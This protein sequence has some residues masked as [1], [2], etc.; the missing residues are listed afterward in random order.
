MVARDWNHP[1]VMIWTIVNENWG[2]DLVK[3]AADRQWLFE[4]VTWARSIAPTR[5]IV[6]NS[7]CIP[8]FH[9]Q[10]DID[11]YHFYAAMPEGVKAWQSYVS[12]FAQR[13]DWSFSPYGD[14]HRTGREPLIISEFGNWGLPDLGQLAAAY[15]GDPWW[16]RT[17]KDWEPDV[18]WPQ[19]AEERFNQAG[20]NHVFSNWA[21]LA[22]AAQWAQYRAL[23]HEIEV[24]R[25]EP[26]LSGYVITEWTDLHWECNGLVD[27]AR[28]PR[29]FANRMPEFNAD[30]VIIPR[31]PRL[32]YWSGEPVRLDIQ[33]AH[34]GSLPL[35]Q[36]R[37]Y[38]CL[39]ETPIS[40]SF[41]LTLQPGDVSTA[42][43][44]E[45]EVPSLL[46][47]VAQ[48]IR[49]WLEDSQQRVIAQNEQP[50]TLLPGESRRALVGLSIASDDPDVASWLD[51][52]GYWKQPE[53]DLKIV[54]H[55]NENLLAEIEAGQHVLCCLT[56][57]GE[58]PLGLSVVAR[59][60]T[61]RSGDWASSFAW[62]RPGISHV[63]DQPLLD[64][65]WQDI[66][67]QHVITG[68]DAEHTLAGLFVGWIHMPAALL[69]QIPIGKGLLTVTTFPM[70]PLDD[71]PARTIFMHDLIR[72]AAKS[73]PNQ[74]I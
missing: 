47:A 27:M 63:S 72:L 53:T 41:N 36:A 31:M 30:T 49:F 39:D 38:W 71:S 6:D 21:E 43:T 67:P 13:P 3:S 52:H 40:G 24:M 4:T 60:K 74:T 28:N 59:D 48:P 64:F 14:I 29:V 46:E 35:E 69:A 32:L 62:I 42:K 11:D 51:T 56:H 15:G 5:L 61:P 9:V 44:I 10:T 25:A 7:A 55:F 70:L 34:Y 2:T 22:Q 26:T 68:V 8:N 1:S 23:K 18:V 58:L 19:N 37:L 50:L 57:P 20:L 12:T 73:A 54:S 45:F 65:K 33:V 17:G 66:L 16:F